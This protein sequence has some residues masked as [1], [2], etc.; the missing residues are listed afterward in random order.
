MVKKKQSACELHCSVNSKLEN[1]GVCGERDTSKTCSCQ[2][3]KPI[4][5]R[6]CPECKSTEV[7][8]VFKMKNLF[9]LVP[10][11][12]CT[13][14]GNNGI[15]FP[16]VIVKPENLKKKQKK[17]TKDIKKKIS[18]GRTAR[19]TPKLENKGAKK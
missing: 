7:K 17:G 6:F 16:V 4:K 19:C 3:E 15:E 11:I 2:N 5:V 18:K 9:G 14:C 10:R 12:E 1:K 13:K 8:F